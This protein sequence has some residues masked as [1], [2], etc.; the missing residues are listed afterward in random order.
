MG[1]LREEAERAAFQQV[2][3]LADGL[4]YGQAGAAHHDGNGGEGGSGGR[5]GGRDELGQTQREPY[6]DHDQRDLQGEHRHGGDLQG[7]ADEQGGGDRVAAL[8]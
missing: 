3:H 2:D 5:P 4:P 1:G 8:V 6:E 7:G